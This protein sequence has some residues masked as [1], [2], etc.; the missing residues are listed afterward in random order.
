MGFQPT[1][2]PAIR[3]PQTPR[4]SGRPETLADLSS[5]GEISLWADLTSDAIVG[6]CFLVEFYKWPFDQPLHAA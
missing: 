1:D 6:I 3:S 4:R 5:Q 2:D